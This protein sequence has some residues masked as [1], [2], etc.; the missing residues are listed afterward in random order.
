MV[1]RKGPFGWRHSVRV[2]FS[3]KR[4]KGPSLRRIGSLTIED[5]DMPRL[6]RRSSQDIEDDD[7]VPDVSKGFILVD[8]E[9]MGDE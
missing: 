4:K 6:E 2:S 3:A 5:L 7:D 8:L 1:M 9:L